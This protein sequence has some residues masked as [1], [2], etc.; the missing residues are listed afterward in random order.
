MSKRSDIMPGIQKIFCPATETS[1][2]DMA[3]GLHKYHNQ[4]F[5]HFRKSTTLKK[6]HIPNQTFIHH[7]LKLSSD[8]QEFG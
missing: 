8:I 2:E 5:T 3:R 7:S 1:P 6:A 4:T